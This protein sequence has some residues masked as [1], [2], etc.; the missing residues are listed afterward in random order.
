MEMMEWMQSN[1][2]EIEIEMKWKEKKRNECNGYV[3]R[4]LS[5]NPIIFIFILRSMFL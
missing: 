2:M 3:V 4:L 1:G 5:V